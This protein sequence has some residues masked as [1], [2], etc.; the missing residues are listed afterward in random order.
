MKTWK[1]IEELLKHPEKEFTRGEGY[2]NVVIDNKTMCFKNGNTGQ[3]LGDFVI[4][5]STVD[6]DWTEVK[7]KVCWEEALRHM[8]KHFSHSAKCPAGTFRWN[9]R[10]ERL[11]QYYYSTEVWSFATLTAEMLDSEEW[12]LS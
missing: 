1:M 9:S 7:P 5:T 3:L 10:C 11:M 4:M 12:E 2:K 8:R 6:T